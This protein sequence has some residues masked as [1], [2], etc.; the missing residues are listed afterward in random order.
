MRTLTIEA[1]LDVATPEEVAQVLEQMAC[2]FDRAAD[3]Y[4][5]SHIELQGAWGDPNAGLVWD[6][7][8]KRMNGTASLLR[9]QAK[10]CSHNCHRYV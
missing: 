10:R 4:G 5:E 2:V 7:L 1:D 6:H 8:A 3:K 9:L